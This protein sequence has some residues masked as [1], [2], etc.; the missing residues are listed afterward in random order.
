MLNLHPELEVPLRID[1]HESVSCYCHGNQVILEY[2]W[3]KKHN[4]DIDWTNREV[5]M[6]HCPHSCYLLQEKSIFLQMLEKEKTKQ[7]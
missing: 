6:T 7:V 3:L 4:P 2:T 1:W 5:K